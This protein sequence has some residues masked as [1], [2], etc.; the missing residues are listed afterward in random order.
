MIGGM[1]G[2]PGTEP[3]GT[4]RPA[5][6][7]PGAASEVGP[8]RTVVLH[9]PGPG[10]KGPA[11]RYPPDLLFDGIPWV[12]KAQEEHDTFADAL[13]IRGVEVL[14]L[15]DLVVETLAVAVAR[16]AVVEE[17]VADQRLGATL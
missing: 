16:D 7:R 13:R 9:R 11:P 15:R 3:A 5:T 12:E 10:L 17:T 14:Y 2:D 4:A 6:P 8:L 1:D